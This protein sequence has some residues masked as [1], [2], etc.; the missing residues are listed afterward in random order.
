MKKNELS[1]DKYRNMIDK[2]YDGYSIYR[3]EFKKL[4]NVYDGILDKAKV[5]ELIARKK[6]YI[7]SK[8]T[9]SLVKR[10]VAGL[11]NSYFSNESLAN[12]SPLSVG[13]QEELAIKCQRAF[14]FYWNKTGMKP[15]LPMKKNFLDVSIYGT[16]IAKCYWAGNRLK[17][18]YINIHNCWF[19]PSASTREDL[20]YVVHK[21]YQTQDDIKAYKD[22]G[23]Y[24]KRFKLSDISYSRVNEE[25]TN[26]V[27]NVVEMTRIP[28]YDVYVK[29]NGK[30]HLTTIYNK[31]TK[32][33]SEVELQDGL[34][35]F[36]GSIFPRT[37]DPDVQE[38]R[39]YEDSIVADTIELQ[40]ELTIRINQE[41]DAIAEIINP[42]YFTE[43]GSGLQ[44]SK[45]KKGAGKVVQMNDLTKK[46]R[47][48]EAPISVLNANREDLYRAMKDT[49]GIDVFINPD[50]SSMLNRQST[51]N[52]E[53]ISGEQNV[54][55]DDYITQYN[56]TYVEPLCSHAMNLIWKY[57]KFDHLLKGLDRTQDIEF[58]VSINAGLGATS[59]TL[60]LQGYDAMFQKFMAVQ[61]IEKANL[62]IRDSLGLMG[63][64]NTTDYFPDI[65]DKEAKEEKMKQAEA[66]AQKQQEAF[67]LEKAKAQA[68]LEKI[69]AETQEKIES[70]RIKTQQLQIDAEKLESNN[71]IGMGKIRNKDR[72]LDLKELEL[73]V[74]MR[75]GASNDRE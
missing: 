17:L 75:Q 45:L 10:L 25:D 35:I 51:D 59:K 32:L 54:K 41:I 14:D 31:D 20:G 12:I 62:T 57:N 37:V 6:S 9:K 40:D 56:E 61:D 18:E 50:N 19:D 48:S 15:Y 44:E 34:P 23:I 64:K 27:D 71:E 53:K 3:D 74:T 8:E 52:M 70:L 43:P 63:I 24:D 72:E 4:K 49:T 67:E 7:K 29:R 47:I 65:D 69:Q 55:M 58:A 28:L 68:E 36:V 26:Y 46:E 22:Q 38:V 33:R 30:W 21:I 42:S 60:R 11:T 5:D 13:N 2:A 16:T 1:I 39:I 73:E 66:E